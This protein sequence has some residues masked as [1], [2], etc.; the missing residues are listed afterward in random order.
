MSGLDEVKSLLLGC[1]DRWSNLHATIRTWRHTKRAE[2]ARNQMLRRLPPLVPGHH[3]GGAGSKTPIVQRVAPLLT[4]NSTAER[5]GTVATQEEATEYRWV[6][7]LSKPE[8]ARLEYRAGSELVTR[9]TR[10]TRFWQW[11]AS[12]RSSGTLKR[13]PPYFFAQ[14]G[15]LLPKLQLT[16]LEETSVLGR[17]CYGVRATPLIERERWPMMVFHEL[18]AG[19]DEYEL[20]VD[21][22]R[23]V[24][25][26]VTAIRT[27]AVF[28][29]VSVEEI[30][31]DNP[32]GD[33]VFRPYGF[34]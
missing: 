26:R 28:Q 14:P 8:L 5:F 1:E 29:V 22:E 32:L 11:S 3:I 23:G 25:L 10:S 4:S 15:D 31:F 21:A 34:T 24:V 17:K 13:F 33:E 9:V 16:R 30:T 2:E 20:V 27:G 18:G 19:A 6:L 12:G 7:W